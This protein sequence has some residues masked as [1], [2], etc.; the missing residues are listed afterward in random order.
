MGTNSKLFFYLVDIF[1]EKS[2]N[3]F[4]LFQPPTHTHTS[5]T[6][7]FLSFIASLQ[8]IDDIYT[9]CMSFTFAIVMTAAITN[10][11]FAAVMTIA[12]QWRT[13]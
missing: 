1:L 4:Y 9:E 10:E 3:K 11:F 7:S 6:L 8:F 13:G 5:I 2:R 12:M